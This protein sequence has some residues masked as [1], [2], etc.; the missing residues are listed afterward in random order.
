MAAF[1]MKP[2]TV[3]DAI[4]TALAKLAEVV[5]ELSASF[6]HHPAN[7][8]KAFGD[9]PVLGV[10]DVMPVYTIQVRKYTYFCVDLRGYSVPAK[11]SK[12]SF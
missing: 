2:S 1:G 8:V 12:C 5:D 11:V 4:V 10:L 9:D 7:N 3:H 6:F